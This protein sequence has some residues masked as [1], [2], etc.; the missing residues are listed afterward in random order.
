[1]KTLKGIAVVAAFTLA[2]IALEQAGPTRAVTP[3]RTYWVKT[4]DFAGLGCGAPIVLHTPAGGT[5]AHVVRWK[6]GNSSQNVSPLAFEYGASNIEFARSPFVG[7]GA[8]LSPV[9]GGDIAFNNT[10]FAPGAPGDAIELDCPFVGETLS[11]DGLV[12][13]YDE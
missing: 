12:F 11:L 6:I 13:G 3:P 7:E 2:M 1:V 5:T 8:N 4:L 10:G 9:A